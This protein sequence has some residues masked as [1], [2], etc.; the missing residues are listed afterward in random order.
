M[1]QSR[2]PGSKGAGCKGGRRKR[3][4][5]APWHEKRHAGFE[6]WACGEADVVPRKKTERNPAGSPDTPHL[7]PKGAT[8]KTK[9]D[10]APPSGAMGPQLHHP[11]GGSQLGGALCPV[12][13]SNSSRFFYFYTEFSVPEWEA[14]I[15]E[16]GRGRRKTASL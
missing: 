13:P 16:S 11:Q 2:V 6:T 15:R 10:P 12:L 3:G 9:P 7:D 14:V 5:T 4:H 1:S 8:P